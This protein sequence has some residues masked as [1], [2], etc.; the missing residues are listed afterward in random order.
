MIESIQSI[1]GTGIEAVVSGILAAMLAQIMKFVGYFLKTHKFD[2]RVLLTTGGMPSSHSA[3]VIGLS[4][5]IGFICGFES[6]E[7]AIAM[8]FSL[9]V[10]YDAAGLRR[11]AGKMAKTINKMTEDIY[12]H[13]PLEAGEKL[14]ELLGHTPIEVA[15]GAIWGA[16]FAYIVHYWL[17]V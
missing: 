11:S 2:Y 8:G 3:G 10:M 4:T 1:K 6:V 17:L 15:M 13:R 16:C 14:K 7:V 12:E 9:V 5:I